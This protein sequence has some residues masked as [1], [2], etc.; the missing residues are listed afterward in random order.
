MTEWG[1]DE[2][3]AKLTEVMRSG[4]S[5][6]GDALGLRSISD[7]WESEVI[8]FSY[9]GEEF[10]LRLYQGEGGEGTLERESRGMRCLYAVGYPVPNVF[11][12]E[13]DSSVLGKPFLVMELVPGASMWP[14]M[15]DMAEDEY[16]RRLSQSAELLVR[17]HSLPASTFP[18][19]P[20]DSG[21]QR[22]N[23][24]IVRLAEPPEMSVFRPGVDWLLSL[25]VETITPTPVHLDF[26]PNNVILKPDGE[27]VVIDWTQATVGDPR[28]DLAW[29]Q[30]LIG[31]YS[32]AEREAHFTAEY[33]K[34]GGCADDMTYFDGFNC[35]KRLLAAARVMEF[36]GESLGMRADAAE[37][38][39]E[40]SAATLK[41]VD[42][43]EVLAGLDLSNVRSVFTGS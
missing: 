25:Q 16:L 29:T 41:V 31:T 23:D 5:A 9:A 7:G 35:L 33:V 2:L 15:S 22:A 37:Q 13:F 28:L 26:H 14:Q 1:V 4:M 6:H 19:E 10:V 30:M 39:K 12:T 36:G 34:F 38:I 43:L 32:T 21:I 11:L 40:S 3:A 18:D 42:R 8:A 17:L 20:Q 27:M 24:S